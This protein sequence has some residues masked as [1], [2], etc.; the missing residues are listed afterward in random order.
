MRSY[1][2][3]KENILFEA[4]VV[5]AR[6]ASDYFSAAANSRRAAFMADTSSSCARVAVTSHPDKTA[7]SNCGGQSSIPP[8]ID[9][10]TAITTPACSTAV[11]ISSIDSTLPQTHP[12]CSRSLDN[13]PKDASAL[14]SD[15]ASSNGRLTN[16][17]LNQYSDTDSNSNHNTL[18]HRPPNHI[19]NGTSDEHSFTNT[20]SNHA[21]S[22]TRSSSSNRKRTNVSSNVAPNCVPQVKNDNANRAKN[23]IERTDIQFRVGE[24]LEA[25]DSTGTWYPAKIVSVDEEEQ[26]V[27]IH[28]IRWSTRFDQWMQMD[29]DHLR[30][31][32]TMVAND[33]GSNADGS[34][35]FKVGDNVLAIWTD[36]KKYPGRIQTVLSDGN[37]NILFYDGYRKKVRRN[38]VESLPVG[39]DVASIPI[40][41][42]KGRNNG[43]SSRKSLPAQLAIESPM[44]VSK[45]PAT[46]QQSVTKAGRKKPPIIPITPT[47]NAPVGVLP[48][49]TKEFV[50]EADHNQFKCTISE[51]NKSFRKETLLNS[52]IKHY[53]P[54]HAP[55]T[56]IVGP[57]S[58]PEMK[59]VAS[60]RRRSAANKQLLNTDDKDSDRSLSNS[61]FEP[62][63]DH[64]KDKV[65]EQTNGIVK[66]SSKAAKTK[67]SL[68]AV[69][70]FVNT[71]FDGSKE[72]DLFDPKSPAGTVAKSLPD[73]SLQASS[74]N[75]NNKKKRRPPTSRRSITSKQP[76]NSHQSSLKASQCDSI[77]EWS[78]ST[79]EDSS[80]APV[81]SE[82]KTSV[83]SR[84]KRAP[85]R[86]SV[87]KVD[88]DATLFDMD[89]ECFESADESRVN[90]PKKKKR[91]RRNDDI[92][93]QILNMKIDLQERRDRHPVEFQ[94]E[95]FLSN[96]PSTSSASESAL[97]ESA[98]FADFHAYDE[99]RFTE[100]SPSHEPNENRA[101]KKKL[102][103]PVISGKRS[104]PDYSNASS[105]LL[106]T[107]L[108]TI[109]WAP[110]RRHVGLR[111]TDPALSSELCSSSAGPAVSAG[112][113][114][115]PLA[116]NE[117]VPT[118]HELPFWDAR[119]VKEIHESDEV[120][121]LVHCICDYKE[122]SGLMIQCE[123]CLTWQH[124]TCFEIEDEQQVPE[125][126]VCF[127]CR[128]P[129]L[130]RE[131]QRFI[132]DQE[133]LS[134]GKF[135]VLLSKTGYSTEEQK[136]ERLQSEC[137]KKQMC[138]ANQLLGILVEITLI[139]KSLRHKLNLI[140]E[141]RVNE[142]QTW[143]EHV[144]RDEL[145][146]T[147]Q[148]LMNTTDDTANMNVSS[149]D[150]KVKLKSEEDVHNGESEM[151]GEILNFSKNI[152]ESGPCGHTLKAEDGIVEE[153]L[154]KSNDDLDEATDLIAFITSGGKDSDKDSL[155]IE[156][157][158][159]D[160]AHSNVQIET[161]ERKPAVRA[162]DELMVDHIVNVHNDL[163]FKL[164][165]VEKKVLELE[166]EMGIDK[167]SERDLQDDLLLFKDTIKGIYRD[168]NLVKELTD[169]H[170]FM[171]NHL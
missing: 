148:Q 15:E 145:M 144:P 103:K 135:P 61:S 133:L 43:S 171:S 155:A 2:K 151:I 88:E 22:S 19:G 131:S 93:K 60:S 73:T 11:S 101:K 10:I 117:R 29:S 163:V 141:N 81:A 26:S 158:S 165:L 54:E 138:S 12:P 113:V 51:C 80:A 64:P 152:L 8:T 100:Y 45:T 157:R 150:L 13:D 86:R 166:V 37:Y 102:I 79:V 25:C 44:V 32:P 38:L 142:M 147:E 153:E 7:E 76:F 169:R 35:Q 4:L 106:S 167:N 139:L 168:L 23:K 33:T 96:T 77:H 104:K 72:G 48:V 99:K 98:D 129:R 40:T 58:R 108:S 36:N 126:Y 78:D 75:G 65:S 14:S 74:T 159:S 20:T 31:F 116:I 110:F 105:P 85:Q 70:S 21:S 140:K 112:P 63:L 134:K 161:K 146:S 16:S 111:Q 66:S 149:D 170:S 30:P 160:A 95:P 49:A 47:V 82:T 39:F 97:A 136:H 59:E 17:P 6:W 164:T 69:D 156:V 115:S 89:D 83:S 143:K 27:L 109:L 127:A 122:E 5:A 125:C 128:D 1:S 62:R 46:P 90:S 71:C 67:D 34:R 121:E 87:Q 92:N 123:V 137:N 119:I 94:D 114:M 68:A 28:F 9:P 118:T 53:H 91:Y 124:G 24:K 41:P 55:P 107:P 154:L 162:V 50:V 52:H 84:K 42:L 132:Y 3:F 18:S 120:D 57:T 56:P 130:G